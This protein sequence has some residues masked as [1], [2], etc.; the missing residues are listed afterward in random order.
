MEFIGKSWEC[1]DRKAFALNGDGMIKFLK[2][3]LNN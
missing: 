1:L 2:S 3:I